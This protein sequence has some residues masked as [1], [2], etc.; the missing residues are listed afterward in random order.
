M[1]DVYNWDRNIL[2]FKGRLNNHFYLELRGNKNIVRGDSATGKTFLCD[3]L[4]KLSGDTNS[5]RPY[6]MDNIIVIN[7]H[8]NKPW[9]H[10]DKDIKPKLVLIDEAALF[11][12]PEDIKLINADNHNRYLLFSREPMGIRVTPNHVADF[13]QEDGKTVMKYRYNVKG[14]C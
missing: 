9:N 11:L 5:G 12:S 4:S 2:E 13:V 6:N 3:A 7:S 10:V 1:V 8:S 14:W